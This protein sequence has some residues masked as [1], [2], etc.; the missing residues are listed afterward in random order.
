MS[1][2]KRKDP[3]LDP[4]HPRPITRRDFVA[5]G[6]MAGISYALVPGV[7]Y[8][9]LRPTPAEA[10]ASCPSNGS[11]SGL[12]PMIILDHVGGI[13]FPSNFIVGKTLGSQD[14]LASY[15]TLGIPDGN[16]PKNQSTS[17][18]VDT[19][20]GAPM[21]KLLSKYYEGLNSVIGN[22]DAK[23]RLRITTVCNSSQDDSR[24]NALSPLLLASKAGL[25]GSILATGLGT[26]NTPSGGN[27]TSPILDP[28]LKPLMVELA[29]ISADATKEA[30]SGLKLNRAVSLGAALNNLSLEQKISIARAAGKMTQGQLTK[31]QNRSFSS[32][33][34]TL[35]E[36]GYLKLPDLVSGASTLDASLNADVQAVFGSTDSKGP[37]AT[38]AYNALKGHTGPGVITLAGCDYHGRTTASTDAIDRSCGE[39]LGR[40]VELANRLKTDVVVM[41]I[42]DGG[43]SYR[44]NERFAV[45]DAATRSMSYIAYY[46][47][48]AIP[49]QVKTQIGAYT[50]GNV[51]DKSFF[52]AENPSLTAQVLF[53][54][55]LRICGKDSLFQTIVSSSS[56]PMNQLSSVLAFG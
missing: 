38:I 7:L 5:Q 30:S 26:M 27:S 24:N 35:A 37:S 40:I 45:S 17:A 18:Q 43:I 54:N 8:Q 3:F 51:V 47:H 1:K 34:S 32:Q 39:M 9:L 31:F 41:G 55:Y 46:K 28:L 50:E 56:F 33:F 48:L 21:H 2:T 6:L 42:T 19:S 12:V 4:D 49:N 23:S 52:F 10:A 20:Y 25:R 22:S 16:N 14:Y 15:S 53:A 29:T 11:V 44:S 13:G 36:C